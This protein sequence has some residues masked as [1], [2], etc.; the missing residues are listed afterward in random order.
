MQDSD[1]REEGRRERIERRRKARRGLTQ[2]INIRRIKEAF[3]EVERRF[4]SIRRMSKRR[5]LT[6][7]R[8]DRRSGF[9]RRFLNADAPMTG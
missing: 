5:A 8:E 2:R 6:R 1:Q 9:D 3:V 7:R 4:F